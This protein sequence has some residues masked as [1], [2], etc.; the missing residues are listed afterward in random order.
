MAFDRPWK[1]FEEQL[2]LLK[3]RGMVVTDETAALDYLERV[4]Y[5]RLSAYW[6][7]F[8][9]SDTGGMIAWLRRP[10]TSSISSRLISFYATY[11]D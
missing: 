4:G 11:V 5:Y 9:M 2:A 8:R 3:M 1:S 6:Y 7:P 10:P